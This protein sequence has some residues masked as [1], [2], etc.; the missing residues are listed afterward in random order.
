MARRFAPT[1]R[2]GTLFASPHDLLPVERRVRSLFLWPDRLSNVSSCEAVLA[3]WQVWRVCALELADVDLSLL[4]VPPDRFFPPVS[5][6]W[7][8][9]R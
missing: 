2:S 6:T 8:C 9:T 3:E 4:S 1:R 7:I 5:F